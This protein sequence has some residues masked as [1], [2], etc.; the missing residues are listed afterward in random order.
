VP[1]IFLKKKLRNVIVYL[2]QDV[3]LLIVALH[4][5]SEIVTNRRGYCLHCTY[6]V[7]GKSVFDAIIQLEATIQNLDATIQLEATIQLN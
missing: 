3:K 7:W 5:I 2:V 6:L 4:G 1:N